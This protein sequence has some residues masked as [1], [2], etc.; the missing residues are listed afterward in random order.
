MILSSN[1]NLNQFDITD[2]IFLIKLM[3][4]GFKELNKLIQLKKNKIESI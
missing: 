4:G 3:S 1:I 2:I